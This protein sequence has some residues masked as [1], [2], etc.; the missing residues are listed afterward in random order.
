MKAYVFQAALHCGPCIARHVLGVPAD[1]I[2]AAI[3][4]A[5]K[6]AGLQEGETD[7]GN[8]PD[9]PIADG[10]GESDAPQSCDTCRTFLRNPLTAE[11][12]RYVRDSI[13]EFNRTGSGDLETLELWRDFY[14]DSVQRF[15]ETDLPEIDIARSPGPFVVTRAASRTYG[16][17]YGEHKFPTMAEA[18]SHAKSV[19]HLIADIAPGT[20]GSLFPTVLDGRGYR[21][22]YTIRLY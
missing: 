7:T 4:K 12:R 8:V 21:I 1:R 19:A 13:E 5:R 20:G 10:G 6:D 11:G 17:D 16:F 14:G 18:I 2:R 9:G 15:G 3:E 22:P